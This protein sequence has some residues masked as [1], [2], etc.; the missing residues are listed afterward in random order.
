M[1][2]NGGPMFKCIAVIEVDKYFCLAME[3]GHFG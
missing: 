1:V 2:Q 3:F